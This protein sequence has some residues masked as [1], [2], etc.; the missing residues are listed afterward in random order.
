MSGISSL[1]SCNDGGVVV[2]GYNDFGLEDYLAIKLT[3]D[4]Q[5][6]SLSNSPLWTN[7][8]GV[9]I[10]SPTS[11]SSDMNIY[12][13]VQITSTGSLTIN[14]SATIH[15]ASSLETNDFDYLATNNFA[16]PTNGNWGPTRI[17]IEP[18]GVLVLEDNATLSSIDPH[19]SCENMWDGVIVLG[20]NTLNQKVQINQGLLTMSSNSKIENAYFGAAIGQMEFHPLYGFPTITI[21][22]GGG[23]IV[24]NGQSTFL[25]CHE[26]VAFAPYKAPSPDEKINLSYFKYANFI[27]DQLLLDLTFVSSINKC[28]FFK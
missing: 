12:G 1:A 10:T 8:N 22:N 17:I 18:G 3:N 15:F 21:N 25:N 28:N 4:C 11:W 16:N 20:N 24:V 9:P 26:S 23:V 5:V 13:T 7:Y 14:S 6:L 27:N 19:F 2:A